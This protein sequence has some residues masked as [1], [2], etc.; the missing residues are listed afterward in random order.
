MKKMIFAA[1]AAVAIIALAACKNDKPAEQPAA[2]PAAT[3]QVEAPE[4][5]SPAEAIK[6]EGAAIIEVL[7]ACKSMDDLE[8][9]NKDV[10][11]KMKAFQAK[12]EELM[13]S[14]PDEQKA[15]VE[16]AAKEFKDNFDKVMNDKLQEI[17]KK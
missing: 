7:S 15:E 4:A 17:M 14:L 11:E 2:E 12:V 8:A 16:A 13:A 5:A 9:A 10:D 1:F 3:E 6:K